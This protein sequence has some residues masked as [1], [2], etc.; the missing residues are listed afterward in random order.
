MPVDAAWLPPRAIP[1]PRSAGHASN[2]IVRLLCVRNRPNRPN[3]PTAAFSVILD[4]LRAIDGGP[5]CGWGGVFA[6]SLRTPF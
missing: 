1:S 6:G 4:G 5:V 2:I 3:R